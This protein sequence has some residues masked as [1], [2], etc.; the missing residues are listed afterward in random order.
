M[1][2]HVAG[3]CIEDQVS[4]GKKEADCYEPAERCDHVWDCPLHGQDERGC[5]EFR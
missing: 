5:G 4:C 3:V 2:V 1:L